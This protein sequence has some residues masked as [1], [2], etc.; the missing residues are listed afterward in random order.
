MSASTTVIKRHTVTATVLELIR[1]RIISGAYPGGQQ[2]RQ[3]AIAEEFGVS[4]IPIRE[5]LVQLEAEGFVQIHTHKG[6][7]VAQLT[8]DDAID[9]FDARLVLEPS[10]LRQAIAKASEEDVHRVNEA[11]LN[12]ERGVAAEFSPA[13]LSDLNWAF[14]KALSASS[15][16]WRSLSVLSSLYKSADRYLRLQIDSREARQNALHDHRAIAAAF[17][18]GDGVLAQKLLSKHISNARDDVTKNLKAAEV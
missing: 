9:I 6:A 10:I 4:R 12:Y 5:A 11:L 16:R 7:I 17:E 14:H 13:Q 15:G 3:E 1:D 8:V 18:V 2:I